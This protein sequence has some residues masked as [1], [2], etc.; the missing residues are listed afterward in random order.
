MSARS[1]QA[2]RLGC[3]LAA[4]LG[5]RHVELRWSGTKKRGSFGGWRVEWTNGPTVPTMRALVA[6]RADLFPAVPAAD[7]GYDR[8]QTDLAEVIA[9]LLY[10]DRNRGWV[11]RIECPLLLWAHEY[12][13]WPERA[14]QVWHHR[15]T[16]LLRY[17]RYPITTASAVDILGRH[18]QTGWDNALAWLD[19]LV[20]EHAATDEASNVIDLASRRV[21]NPDRPSWS[22]A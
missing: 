21:A 2:A 22:Q 9:L 14:D 19:R 17:A 18:A 6:E 5:L 1:T 10:V 16:A 12:I 13:D 20:A 7:L 8:C 11:D 15:A 3:R 4:D